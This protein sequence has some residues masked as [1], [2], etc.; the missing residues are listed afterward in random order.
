MRRATASHSMR[1]GA[2][3]PLLAAVALAL[4][5]MPADAHPHV[6]IDATVTP[7]FDGLGRFAAVH[8]RW[9]FD[10]AFTD[11]ILSDLDVNRDGLLEES[12]IRNAG[13]TG[14][15]WFVP[16]GYFTRITFA[17]R[18]VATSGVNDF[19]V[20]IPGP[21]LVLELTLPLA[22]PEAVTAG[23]GIDVFD[24]DIYVDVE[25]AEPGIDTS[26]LPA[27]CQAGRRQQPNLDP[28]AVMLIRK[29]GLS[30]DP[31]VLNDPAA[32]FAFRV[33]IDCK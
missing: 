14:S 25:F 21:R 7:I 30:T 33:A 20:T 18:P 2:C 24:P 10:Q 12:E 31:S 22:E 23:A 11:S 3:A 26:R 4:C 9:T 5:V 32:G 6:F 13:A 17:G 27:A 16:Y 15:L 1:R 19:S 28:T 29:L 8:E